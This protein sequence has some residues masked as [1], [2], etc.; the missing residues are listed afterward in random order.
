MSGASGTKNPIGLIDRKENQ[1]F[2]LLS[3]AHGNYH[4]TR[5]TQDSN[6]FLIYIL[7]GFSPR[8]GAQ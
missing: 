6:V 8:T 3:L 5:A 4:A 1:S 2:F 7:R